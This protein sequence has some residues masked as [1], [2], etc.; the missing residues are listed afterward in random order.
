M[1]LK[2]GSIIRTNEFLSVDDYIESPN[3]KFYA[4]MQGDGNFVVYRGTRDDPQ[5]LLWHTNKYGDP[6]KFFAIMQGDGNFVVY[7]GASPT[8]QQGL[9]WHTKK[10]GDPGEFFAVIQDDGNFV[11]YKGTSPADYQE[12]WWATNVLD[13]IDPSCWMEHIGGKIA[14][15][16]PGRL[17]IPGT[18]DSGS[19]TWRMT[20]G[21]RTQDKN[22]R[23][24]LERGIRSLDLRVRH[25]H[26]AFR[27]YYLCH[28]KVTASDLQLRPA[29]EQVRG[30]VD[31]H[32]KEI[33]L[34]DFHELYE[35]GGEARM[36]K[37]AIDTL[38]GIIRECF[39][40]RLVDRPETPNRLTVKDIWDKNQNMIVFISDGGKDLW[41]QSDIQ[42]AWDRYATDMG[43][44]PEKKPPH[45][46]DYMTEELKN[47][48]TLFFNMGLTIST[49]NLLHAATHIMNPKIPGWL[50]GWFHDS[51]TKNNMNAIAVDFLDHPDGTIVQKMIYLNTYM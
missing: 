24:Q 16:H 11:V 43:V 26:P 6:G 34:L 12:V 50:D 22:F 37:N 41:P 2:P 20:I 42:Y 5:G 35:G 25:N 31:R 17:Y 13:P 45:L 27:G 29:L 7:K 47:R 21:V 44:F 23:E 33:V 32:P 10:H 1:A 38:K 15:R 36:S 39:K 40:D 51:S 49:I 4:I 3:R 14:G 9:W 8:D 46:H 18:H 19:Y 30:F 28:D 48:S